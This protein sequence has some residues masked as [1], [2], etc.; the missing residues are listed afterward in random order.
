MTEL[1]KDKNNETTIENISNY[2]FHH[3]SI[4]Y[5]L[6]NVSKIGVCKPS[7]TSEEAFELAFRCE[8]I[9]LWACLRI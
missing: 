6:V 5:M 4:I 2:P 3:V 1:K 7:E 8:T 9:C